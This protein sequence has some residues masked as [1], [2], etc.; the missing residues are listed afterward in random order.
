MKCPCCNGTGQIEDV[1]HARL[2]PLQARIYGIILKG[3]ISVAG[4]TEVVYADRLDGGPATARNTISVTIHYANQRLA[5]V[6]QRIV[7]TKGHG[8]V[9]RLEHFE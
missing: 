5:P 6:H 9:Y 2:T 7:S 3:P 8:S 4:L 1:A